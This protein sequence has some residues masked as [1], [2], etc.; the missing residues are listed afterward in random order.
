[1]QSCLGILPGLLETI[2]FKT[3]RMSEL[4]DANFATATELA[5]Y[6]AREHGIAFRECHEIVGGVVGDLAEKGMTFADLEETRKLLQLRGIRLS[7]SQLQQ[8]L[9][10]KHALRLNRSLGGTSPAEVTRMA[11]EFEVVL[12]GIDA[13]ILLRREQI[14]VA[15]KQTH[16][17]IEEVIAGKAISKVDSPCWM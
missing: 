16:R 13:K 2:R 5:N 14:D 17:I 12:E 15:Y 8:L 11:S 6:L 1:M 3:D 7:A 4:C 9:N 10:S